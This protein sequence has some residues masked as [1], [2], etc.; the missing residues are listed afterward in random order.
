MSGVPF[1]LVA[2]MTALLLL[3]IRVIFLVRS[4]FSSSNLTEFR[5]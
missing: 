3:C 1:S 4:S 2:L 5:T